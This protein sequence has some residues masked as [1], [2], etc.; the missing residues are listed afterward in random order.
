MGRRNVIAA[1]VL[2]ALGAGY[3]V[4]T[5]GLPSR[6]I[7]DTPEPS[8]FP[9]VVTGSLL[10]LAFGLLVQGIRQWSDGAASEAPARG[11]HRRFTGLAW[12]A[13]YLAALPSLG[14]LVATVPFFAGLMVLYGGARGPWLAV[15]SVAMPAFLFYVFRDGFQILLPLGILPV[16][17][18]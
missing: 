10:A 18:G 6:T 4:L 16:W 13:L 9:W 1:L 15:A 8:F 7:P 12:F 2:L 17:L 3:G 5:T 14:F 11:T